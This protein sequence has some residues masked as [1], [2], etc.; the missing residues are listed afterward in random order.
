MGRPH[1][2]QERGAEMNCISHK[3]GEY[4]EAIE[5]GWP[6]YEFNSGSSGKDDVL[7]GGPEWGILTVEDAKE[8]IMGFYEL[9]VWPESWEVREITSDE[10]LEWANRQEGLQ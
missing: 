1:G 5:K 2:V 6:I 8:E 3:I 10:F 7:I 4:R 9:K